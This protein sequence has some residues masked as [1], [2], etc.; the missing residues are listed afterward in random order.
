MN[1]G[2]LDPRLT[3]KARRLE[4]HWVQKEGVYSY[5]KRTEVEEKGAK[6]IPL[7]W[8]DTNKGDNLRPEVRSR[9]CVRECKRRRGVRTEAELDPSSVFS[10]MPPLEALKLMMSHQ[11]SAKMSRRKGKLRLKMAHFDISRA[12]FMP[13]AEREIYV[14]LPDEDPKKAEGFVG[15][16]ERGMYGTQDASN[17]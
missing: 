1:G 16:L 8:V 12:H 9:L 14:E 17:L 11:V 10:A 4:L 15:R 2:F 5:T 13:K 3:K 7:L 6:I